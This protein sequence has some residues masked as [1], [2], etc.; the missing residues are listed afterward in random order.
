[1]AERARKIKGFL[2]WC[3][4]KGLNPSNFEHKAPEFVKIDSIPVSS[5]SPKKCQ[6]NIDSTLT[7]LQNGKSPGDDLDGKFRKINQLL[8]CRV[9]QSPE[10]RAQ[11]ITP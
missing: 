3:R 7:W 9:G 4:N 6:N 1:M 10:D 5:R 8:P 11:D 2:N